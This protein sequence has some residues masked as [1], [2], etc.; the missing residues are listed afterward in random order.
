MIKIFTVFLFFALLTPMTV[1]ANSEKSAHWPENQYSFSLVSYEVTRTNKYDKIDSI[2]FVV[3]LE[4]W[5]SAVHN[6]VTTLYSFDLSHADKP[7]A[8]E[9][10][11]TGNFIVNE[12]IVKGIVK[13]IDKN[14]LLEKVLDI[15]EAQHQEVPSNENYYFWRENE[16]VSTYLDGNLSKPETV[17]SNDEIEILS[18]YVDNYYTEKGSLKVNPFYRLISFKEGYQF[19]LIN[20]KYMLISRKWQWEN[21]DAPPTDATSAV[22]EKMQWLD[23][24]PE[25]PTQQ[26]IL[27]Q[28][29]L[30]IGLTQNSYKLDKKALPISL[31]TQASSS[32][33]KYDINLKQ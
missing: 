28:N 19:D 15:V 7:I 25:N 18:V 14:I 23:L 8:R 21:N 33:P 2:N 3:D 6:P 24:Y 1:N 22:D 13:S 5:S 31:I 32:P 20:N 16:L 29:I 30:S 9:P 11:I 27:A 17:S 4:I 12:P 10:K 26:D